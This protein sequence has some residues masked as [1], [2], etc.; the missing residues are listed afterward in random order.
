[1]P[2]LSPGFTDWTLVANANLREAWPR[3]AP[4]AGYYDGSSPLVHARQIGE[5]LDAGIGG[6]GIYHFFNK[7]ISL[8]SG[9]VW[10]NDHVIN[11]G[12]KWTV[13]LDINF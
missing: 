8:L 6:F 10:F 12:W 5:A 11:G 2:D 13:Q 1:M 7:D 9:P 4:A 3:R